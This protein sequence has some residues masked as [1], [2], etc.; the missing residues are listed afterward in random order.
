[1]A[2]SPPGSTKSSQQ[3]SRVHWLL[4]GRDAVEKMGGRFVAEEDLKTER[5]Y[6]YGMVLHEVRSL[7]NA[8]L[9]KLRQLEN[10]A[11]SEV[12]EQVSRL[13]R[14]V[15][16]RLMQQSEAD[17]AERI[18]AFTEMRRDLGVQR[19]LQNQVAAVQQ[20]LSRMRATVG[21][22][23]RATPPLA[24]VPEGDVSVSE[25]RLK[26]LEAAMADLRGELSG[27]QERQELDVETSKMQLSEL[28]HDLGTLKVSQIQALQDQA[29]RCT[30]DLNRSIQGVTS[31]MNASQSSIKA[32][33]SKEVDSLKKELDK[34]RWT[35]NAQLAKLKQLEEGSRALSQRIDEMDCILMNTKKDALSETTLLKGRM[36]AM[37]GM[38]D[39]ESFEVLELRRQFSEDQQKRA[40]D[41]LQ[42]A[43]R[44]QSIEQK[45]ASAFSSPAGQAAVPPAASAAFQ[46][47]AFVARIELLEK[48]Q[49][50]LSEAIARL[51][52]VEQRLPDGAKAQASMERLEQ[53]ERQ[54]PALSIALEA[55]KENAVVLARLETVEAL[56]LGAP[57]EAAPPRAADGDVAHLRNGL[58]ELQGSIASTRRDVDK[59]SRDLVEERSERFRALAEVGRLTEDVAKATA[60]TIE[61][62]EKRLLQGLPTIGGSAAAELRAVEKELAD[63]LGNHSPDA[64]STVSTGEERSVRRLPS[65]DGDLRGALAMHVR[66]LTAGL[67]S[68]IRSDVAMRVSTTEARV[69]ALEARIG[70]DLQRSITEFSARVHVLDSAQLPIRV[71]SLEQQARKSSALLLSLLDDHTTKRTA[72]DAIEQDARRA[73]LTTDDGD[74]LNASIP[75]RYSAA[76]SGA[77]RTPSCT[78]ERSTRS[79]NRSPF[80]GMLGRSPM[81]SGSVPSGPAPR[82]STTPP[83]LQTT[84]E[85]EVSEENSVVTHGLKESLEGLV[86]AV[87]RTLHK[88]QAN[89]PTWDG[90]EGARSPP[91]SSSAVLPS[92]RGRSP[93]VPASALRSEAPASA[94]RSPD[95][96]ALTRRSPEP[97]V[98]HRGVNAAA[99]EEDATSI[100]RTS[101]SATSAATARASAPP[102]LLSPTSAS[103]PS[104]ALALSRARLEQGLPK[105][106]QAPK[107]PGP[108]PKLKTLSPSPS[109]TSQPGMLQAEVTRRLNLARQGQPTSRY[110]ANQ[111]N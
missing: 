9:E 33:L 72:I 15:S 54:L 52:L 14:D 71:T 74:P 98:A 8:T 111:P 100:P 29:L 28:K 37:A 99:S 17:R 46:E 97:P 48:R 81:G 16:S 96:P 55:T 25:A 110:L 23:A 106:P 83:A 85:T 3:G 34:E 91:S 60:S 35:A 89:S 67:C 42:L 32:D 2:D 88:A 47:D 62:A 68:E 51:E 57:T 41:G 24:A 19:D 49:P 92:Y 87:H 44:L 11:R 22:L 105:G 1:M 4:H 104:P 103:R 20:E 38:R 93:E 61:K 5:E 63:S 50:V 84:L 13:Q 10:T 95:P 12:E 70:G 86:S 77:Q 76:L 39:G 82:D 64:L 69:G 53:L 43:S 56:C 31:A 36:E 59:L 109:P 102:S 101:V 7:E 21:D 75:S 90:R 108:A 18:A 6:W 94:P 65:N 79:N 73:F 45:V 30:S 107:A 40:A 66:S 58:R 27:Q 80:I 78:S 26:G